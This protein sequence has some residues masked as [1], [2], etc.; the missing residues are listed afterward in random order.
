MSIVIS[1]A[2]DYAIGNGLV[3]YNTRFEL[4]HA[5]FS[6]TPCPV[7]RELLGQLSDLTPVANGV[8]IKIA[9][10]PAFL[11]STL[12]KTARTDGFVRNLLN[13]LPLDDHFSQRQLLISRNDFLLSAGTGESS[14]QVPKQVEFN[15]ISN[16][17]LA[18]SRQISLLHRHLYRRGLITAEP[19][20]ND[21]LE[22]AVD[23]MAAVIRSY[24]TVAPCL[25]MVVQ[26]REQN[27]F[28][29][30][31]L[32]FR[33]LEK[34]GYPT[35]RMTLKEISEKGSLQEGHLKIDGYTAAL[36]YFRAGYSPDD[37]PGD[38]EWKARSLIEHSSSVKCP[39]VGMQLAGTKKIQQLLGQADI[40]RMFADEAASKM[41]NDTCVGLYTLDEQV[42]GLTAS[43][44][45]RQSPARY[46]LKPQREGGG[47][48]L[49]GSEMKTALENL[50]EEQQHAYILMERIISTPAPSALVVEATC[51]EIPSISE[52]GRYGV[53][54]A[55]GK[56]LIENR[57][58]GY[59]VRT[60]SSDKDEGGVCAGYACL[61]SLCLKA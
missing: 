32:E 16:S 14:R 21:P 19:I 39:S 6:L 38:T 2:V 29:Q 36:T 60:K 10:D 25:L 57:D 46:V 33:L 50:T 15:T 34:H 30:R 56:T 58:I 4:T 27:I 28:D 7:S 13:L 49:Y 42:G 53:C 24:D 11:K 20:P 37:Y 51:E 47:N 18:L 8:W 52:I 40:L 1:E 3:K 12:E 55:D 35:C 59:L 54:F 5:P 31:A 61:N 48:N 45:A 9:N 26:E 23:T 22:A 44:K 41:I 17:F 43:E